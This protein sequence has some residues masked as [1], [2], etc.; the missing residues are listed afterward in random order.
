VFALAG[1]TVATPVALDVM[2]HARPASGCAAAA[3]T[4]TVSVVELRG[5]RLAEDGAIVTLATGA[6]IRTVAAPPALPLVAVMLA[7][8][9]L[10]NDALIATSPF[11][12]D[13]P[14]AGAAVATA[15]LLEPIVTT[16]PETGLFAPSRSRTVPGMEP[17][18]IN[19]SVEN[20]TVTED[21]AATTLTVSA[22][23]FP[24]TFAEMVALPGETAVIK[25]VDAF[26]VATPLALVLQFTGRPVNTLLLASRREAVA[27]SV[28]VPM[29]ES[30]GAVT[31]TVLTA[32]RILTTN[33]A[34]VLPSLDAVTFVVP[35]PTAVIS[36]VAFTVATPAALLLHV[37]GRPVSTA[38]PA[39]RSVAAA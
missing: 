19:E 35:G 29:I 20:V 8:P 22:P 16:R 38:L 33:G 27:C 2:L 32:D 30:A 26:T 10:T 5:A 4:V 28:A 34:L 31:V 6:S 14:L 3:V 25:P 23:V 7:V 24:S 11:T 21:T 17:A 36:A 1:T 12:S 37:V 9:A 15:G 13:I 18:P 39:S